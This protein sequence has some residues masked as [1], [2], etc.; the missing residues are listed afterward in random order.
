MTSTPKFLD[1]LQVIILEKPYEN[2]D[3]E[4]GRQMFSGL[5]ALKIKGYLAIHNDGAM[6]VD[7]TDFI[8]N[9]IIVTRKDDP[10]NNILMCYKSTSYSDCQKFN[11]PFPFLQLLKN[12]AHPECSG[13]MEKILA[14]C[15]KNEEEI[16]YDTGWTICPSVRDD[17]ELQGALK[18]M[19]TMFAINHH[20]DY[21]VNHW[22][23]LGILKVKTDQYF[24]KMGLEEISSRPI[25]SHPYLHQ[26]EARAVIS[27]NANYSGYTH[28]TAKKYDNL[29][30]S[31]MT[32]EN[33]SKKVGKVA[34]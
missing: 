1:N 19:I 12:A 9:H 29:W 8:A 7:T 27:K 23:T 20:R 14:D 3:T 28:S 5:M 11:I 32:I 22:V 17:K 15:T 26:T 25:I 6:P 4:F 24:L 21:G 18:E 16:T 31:R 2:L 13:E 10:A 30:N 34:A 33:R